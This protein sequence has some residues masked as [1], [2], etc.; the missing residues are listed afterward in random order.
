MKN[1][2]RGSVWLV[3]IL[4]LVLLVGIGLYF[5]SKNKTEN[6]QQVVSSD[7]TASWKTYSD[8]KNGIEF[9]YPSDWTVEV[10]NSPNQGDPDQVY[11]ISSKLNQ[12]LKQNANYKGRLFSINISIYSPVS[13]I[14]GSKNI[15]F[16]AWYR[17]ENKNNPNETTIVT[18]DGVKGYSTGYL[19]ESEGEITYLMKD[20][21]FYTIDKDETIASDKG[22]REQVLSTFKFTSQ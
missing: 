16:E 11:I 7:Q 9:Q 10:H 17:E 4:I 5:Y 2:Q 1:R 19:G 13:E 22:L 15:S 3:V 14:T 18:I 8:P 21:K 12:Q 6:L 20:N